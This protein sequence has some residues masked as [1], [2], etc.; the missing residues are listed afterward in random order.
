MAGASSRRKAKL[1]DV[2][3]AMEQIAKNPAL[4]E[5][6]EKLHATMRRDGF[7]AEYDLGV[8]ANE[9]REEGGS[10][11]VRTLARKLGLSEARLHVSARVVRVF[12]P[13][14]ARR[15]RAKKNA[16]GFRISFEQLVQI[17]RVKDE[18]IREQLV[19]QTIHELFSVDELKEEVDDAIE[20]L[21]WRHA[22]PKQVANR[23]MRSLRTARRRLP[24]LE[25]AMRSASPEERKQALHAIQ[26]LRDNTAA[27]ADSLAAALRKPPGWSLS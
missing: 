17:S 24:E 1:R 26:I 16:Y 14:L 22:T 6:F 23:L 8:A 21:W 13:R 4:E 20:R 19:E 9:A 2:A 27:I 15:I 11:M 3:D 25:E 18:T 5:L 12:P 10:V 7:A